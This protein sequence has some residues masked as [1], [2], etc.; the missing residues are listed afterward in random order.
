[1]SAPDRDLLPPMAQLASE[2]PAVFSRADPVA[3]DGRRLECWGA[4]QFLP[5]NQPTDPYRS[6]LLRVWDPRL[7]P[8]MFVGMNPSTATAVTNDPTVRRCIGFAARWG[9]GAL[10]MANLF[11]WRATDPVMMA[12]EAIRG[13]DVIGPDADSYLDL[14]ASEAQAVV[15]AWGS[16]MQHP[17]KFRPMVA[18]RVSRVAAILSGHHQLWCMG[19]CADGQPRHPLYLANDVR[20]DEW[21]PPRE[22]PR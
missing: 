18:A 1:V 14:L 7:K 3:V 9:Y 2:R 11:H 19:V 5:N 4:A 17:P 15:V 13:G 22:I 6:A 10:T 21:V 8:V 20:L 16:L 12:M